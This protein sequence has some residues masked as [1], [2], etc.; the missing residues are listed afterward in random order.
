MNESVKAE[1]FQMIDSIEDTTILDMIKQDVA[2]YK[3]ERD[4][5]DDLTPEQLKGL[6]EAMGEVDRGETISWDEF[7]RE[8]NEWKKR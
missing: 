7:K 8:M 4:I 3:N 1:I 6:E 5:I 2:Y